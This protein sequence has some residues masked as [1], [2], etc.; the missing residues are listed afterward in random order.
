MLFYSFAS[1]LSVG[2]VA[3]YLYLRIYPFPSSFD[4]AKVWWS[5]DKN[6]PSASA[7]A[8]P[9]DLEAR[10]LAVTCEDLNRVTAADV[11]ALATGLSL[12]ELQQ[13]ARVMLQQHR[14][15]DVIDAC[16]PSVL[17]AAMG[18]TDETSRQRVRPLLTEKLGL[19]FSVVPFMPL[20]L[21]GERAEPHSILLGSSGSWPQPRNENQSS[22]LSPSIYRL[23]TAAMP[24]L[25]KCLLAIGSAA[26]SW[27]VILWLRLLP[28]KLMQIW[29]AFTMMLFVI[30]GA[31]AVRPLLALKYIGV[32][33]QTAESVA[34]LVFALFLRTVWWVNPQ[35][36]MTIDF[37]QKPD[38]T[39]Y[40]WED[41]KKE[42]RLAILV[43]H[44]SFW[45]TLAYTCICP[46]PLLLRTRS[47]LKAG[48]IKLP[49]VG[50]AFGNTGHFPVYFKSDEEG[51]FHVDAEKQAPVTKRMEKFIERGGCLALF[52]EGAINKT[53][54][55]LLPFRFGTFATV[56]QYRLPVYYAVFVGNNT[57][58]PAKAPI[59]G[60][61]ADIKV[62]IGGFPTDFDKVNSKDLSVQ[63]HNTMQAVYTD[64]AASKKQS[65]FSILLEHNPER[66]G[67]GWFHSM[68]YG[69]SDDPFD[70]TS[71]GMNAETAKQLPF[72][73]LQLFFGYGTQFLT[74]DPLMGLS[75]APKYDE[76]I[77][78]SYSLPAM[79]I[80]IFIHPLSFFPR[81]PCFYFTE[82]DDCQEVHPLP[83]LRR[84]ATPSSFRL[85]ILVA[86]RKLRTTLAIFALNIA[87]LVVN[88]IGII[89]IIGINVINIYCTF[90]SF[91]TLSAELRQ[92]SLF[93]RFVSV[94]LKYFTFLLFYRSRAIFYIMYGLL[95]IG[96]AI[97]STIA[98]CIAIGTGVVMF[99]VSFFVELQVY[100]DMKEAEEDYEAKVNEYAVEQPDGASS[101]AN[102][103]RRSENTNNRRRQDANAEEN[104]GDDKHAQS[105]EP[106]EPVPYDAF[107]IRPNDFVSA[108]DETPDSPVE[109][110]GERPLIGPSAFA[111]RASI[112]N[113]H[114]QESHTDVTGLLGAGREDVSYSYSYS[115]LPSSAWQNINPHV[116]VDSRVT[117]LVLEDLFPEENKYLLPFPFVILSYNII[118][119]YLVSLMLPATN[120]TLCCAS[121][122]AVGQPWG[123][124][125]LRFLILSLPV[126][127]LFSP[128]C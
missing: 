84:V 88:I 53:P 7:A 95:L 119:I 45:D 112:T 113:E 108:A 117:G 128:S 116:N 9:D 57:T 61:P 8:P 111:S 47:L 91:L 106:P 37:Q 89:T 64:L 35:I 98:G 69:S 12:V 31:L 62:R 99:I 30:P 81:L 82:E 20:Y 42:E 93:R 33:P 15:P 123:V 104:K 41:M 25:S 115:Y 3:L 49:I 58:W 75:N 18:K 23:I 121:Y 83:R 2:V 72:F 27:Y 10:L 26:V 21:L 124:S 118:Y 100:S 40:S 13:A 17:H 120:K 6:T 19:L 76:K 85:F 68:S 92:F 28:K 125:G 59:G 36:R 50:Y 4:S 101:D 78:R 55:T 43:N 22:A 87:G 114:G 79:L 86:F 14:F 96:T 38:G 102:A 103:G 109:G 39:Y 71:S 122:W 32:D 46:I 70:P 60:F 11:E 44:T 66:R 16:S 126:S 90:F 34:H 5:K 110:F 94:W 29:F 80:F 1:S 51:N 52:P 127:R 107:N 105:A 63:V 48:L 74:S 97:L 56:H 67:V 77:F 24:C 73:L 54:D 65:Q